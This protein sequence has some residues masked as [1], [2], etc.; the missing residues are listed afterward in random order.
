MKFMNNASA[1]ALM[2]VAFIAAVSACGRKDDAAVATV[3][4]GIG[5]APPAATELRVDDIQTGKSIGADKSISNSTDDFGVRD[6][7]YV[8]VKTEGSGSGTLAAKWTYQDGQTVE[9]S[10]QSIS[11]MG[12]A[13][14]EFHM[15]KA[16]AWP[17]G[18]YKVEVM[19][20]GTSAGSK[21]FEIK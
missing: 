10:S 21:D 11:P 12:D 8:A 5:M 3:D 15:Q 20:N 14:H 18:N 2:A 6:T 17:A 9:E 1:K 16:T 7:I 13:W 19:L 4:T